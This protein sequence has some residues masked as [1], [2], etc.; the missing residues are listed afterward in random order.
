MDKESQKKQHWIYVLWKVVI[1]SFDVI[2]S[3]I[4]WKVGQGKGW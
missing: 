3:G 2:E 4:E 1:D